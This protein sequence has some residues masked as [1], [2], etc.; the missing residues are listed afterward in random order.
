[1]CR[2]L[3]I[4]LFAAATFGVAAP[5]PALA[6]EAGPLRIEITE[7]VVEPMPIAVAPFFDAGGGAE[8]VTRAVAESFGLA[9][10]LAAPFVITGLVWQLA[11]GF[12]SRLV[13]N[14]QVHVVSA[15][16]QILGGF[17]LLA[18]AVAIMFNTW[19]TGMLRAFSSLPGL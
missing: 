6:Q 3:L 14:I 19:S 8:L 15:P 16:A 11:L 5:L 12:V 18:A 17:A 1:M 7:G 9:L 4:A 13:P 2:P 10:R